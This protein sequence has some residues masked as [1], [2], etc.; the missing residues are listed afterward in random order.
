MQTTPRER[1]YSSPAPQ[2][3]TLLVRALAAAGFGVAFGAVQPASAQTAAAGPAAAAAADASDTIVITANKRRER[4]RDVAGTVS[5]L[6]GDELERRNARDQEDLLKLTPGVQF[7]KGDIGGNVITIRGLSTQAQSDS[8]GTQQQPT[9]FYLEDVPLASPV[10]KGLVVDVLPFDLDRVEVLRGPQGVLFGSGSLGGAVRYLYAKPDLRNAGAAVV[11]G[12]G[13]VAHGDTGTQLY[14]MLNLPMLDNTAA[15]RVVAFDRRDPGYIDNIGTGKTD[16]NDVQQRGGRVLFTIKPLNTLSAT[17]VASTQDNQQGDRFY[18]S[19]DPTKLE[20]K[21]PTDGSGRTRFDFS[22]LTVDWQLAGQTLTSVTGWWR[23]H[24]RGSYNDAELFQSL[25]LP[26]KS[27]LRDSDSRQHASSQELRIASNPGTPFQYVAGAFYQK[28]SSAGKS[29]QI[30]PDATLGL[31]DLVLYDSSSAGSEKAVF[32]D[33][34]LSFGGGWSASLGARY[35]RTS[36]ESA[37]YGTVFGGPADTVSPRSSDSGTTPKL[38]LKYRFADGNMVYALASKGYRYGG[39]NATPPD[40]RPYKSDSLWNY[41]VGARLAPVQNLQLDVTAFLLDW[42]DAQFTTF[43]F[44]GAL[45]FSEIANVGKAKSQGVEM[46]ARYRLGSALDFAASLAYLDA[47][48][49]A[50]VLD[51]SG[52]TIAAGA[53]L[54]GAARLQSALQMNAHFEAPFA[55]QGLFNLT[56]TALGERTMDLPGNYRLGGFA[57]L[58]ANLS[59]AREHWTLSTGLGNVFDRRGML[60]LNS[61]P[62]GGSFAQYYVQRPRTLNVALRYDY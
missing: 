35:Y 20:H 42:K 49:S 60:S 11:A 9:G 37:S 52:K 17:L 4:Q 47:K 13:K 40:F 45:G 18:V 50:D 58:D 48:T 56:H 5:V 25:G 33:G 6:Q 54:P 31:T 19:P 21:A 57:T 1:P 7:N 53:R 59:F 23:N 51:A 43:R 38:A 61:S 8:G 29:S 26:V 22:S 15:L 12:V 30:D 2:R 39:A 55:S 62:R 46:A 27:V 3:R 28:S 41:E 36:S 34:E 44:S 16:T 14:G 24:V 32:A 10:G